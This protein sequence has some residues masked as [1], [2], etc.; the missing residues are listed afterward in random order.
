MLAAASG[1]GEVLA[2]EDNALAMLRHVSL[3]ASMLVGYVGSGSDTWAVE[4]SGWRHRA[5]V[6]MHSVVSE[7]HNRCLGE[8]SLQRGDGLAS[9]G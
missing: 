2:R 9:V 1:V 8:K 3:S 7:V 5:A 6:N 4:V